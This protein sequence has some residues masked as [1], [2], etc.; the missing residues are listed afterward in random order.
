MCSVKKNSL[1]KVPTGSDGCIRCLDTM[2]VLS[3]TPKSI[4]SMAADMLCESC[5]IPR[6]T[7]P[8]VKSLPVF[9][10]LLKNT[11]EM[12]GESNLGPSELM[13]WMTAMVPRSK[14]RVTEN[15]DVSCIAY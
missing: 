14:D 6:G 8:H 13:V 12:T 3:F 10:E 5:S 1:H 4:D 2:H 11:A 9:N 7:S 15:T